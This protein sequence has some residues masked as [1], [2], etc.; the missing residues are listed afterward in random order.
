MV[1]RKV[2]VPNAATLIFAGALMVTAPLASSSAKRKLLAIVKDLLV[3]A[4]VVERRPAW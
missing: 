4:V 3:V 1:T 2:R